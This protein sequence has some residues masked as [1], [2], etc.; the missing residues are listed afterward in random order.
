MLDSTL[1]GR[2]IYTDDEKSIGQVKEIHGR[3]FKVDAPMQPDFWLSEECIQS[4]SGDVHLTIPDHLVGDYMLDGPEVPS[5]KIVTGEADEITT[6]YREAGAAAHGHV[7]TDDVASGYRQKW[8]A[9]HG[10]TG[11]RWADYELAYRYGHEMSFDPGFQGRIWGDV[12]SQLRDGYP[13][14]MDRMGHRMDVTWDRVRDSVH[15][16]FDRASARLAA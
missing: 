12:E 8:E 10:A 7:W 2:T 4:V 3:F 9:L 16:A 11:E 13:G 1:I 5:A 6:R 15:D 14:W